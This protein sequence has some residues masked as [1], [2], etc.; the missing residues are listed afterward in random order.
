MGLTM[1]N[2]PA[3]IFLI[4]D[5]P[6]VREGLALLLAQDSHIICGEAGNCAEARARLSD[7]QADVVLLDLH[8][9]KES[10]MDLIGELRQS[11]IR[12]LVY[13]MYEDAGMIRQVFANGANG[14]V[15]K[16]EVSGELVSAVRAVLQG[17]RHVSPVAAQSLVDTM[18]NLESSPHEPVLSEREQQIIILLGQGCTNHDIADEL[19]LSVRTV[20]T[21]CARAIEKLSLDGMKGLRRFAIEHLRQGAHRKS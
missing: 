13:S 1:N 14:Y 5:H 15:C 4:D 3:S 10:G 11:G 21:Y 16:R 20:E 19:K 7:C 9:G 8:L 2:S 6:A 18:I 17:E 12:V